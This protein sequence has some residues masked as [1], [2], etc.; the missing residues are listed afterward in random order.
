[1]TIEIGFTDELCNTQYAPLAILMAHYQQNQVL[2]PLARVQIAMKRRDFSAQDKLK[3]VLV[4]I[5]SGCETFL[6]INSR[7]KHE[8]VLAKACG[9]LRFADQSNLSR[10]MDALTQMNI[11]QLRAAVQEIWYPNSQLGSHDWRG[12]LWFDFDLSGLTCGKLAEQSQKGYFS[13]K[14]MP[15]AV[16]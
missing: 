9:W 2:Q 3:Q 6:D 8:L 5:L 11:E 12:F 7:L 13:G 1:M 14:K 15:Q 16:N 4:S 10:S